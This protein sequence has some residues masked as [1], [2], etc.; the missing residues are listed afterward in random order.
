MFDKTIAVAALATVTTLAGPALADAHVTVQPPQA[1]AGSHAVLDVR[2]PNEEADQRTLSVAVRFP[3]GI[4]S[5]SYEPVPGWRVRVAT[6]KPATPVQ[7]GGRLL[8]EEVDTVTWTAERSADGIRPGQFRDFPVSILVPEGKAGSTLT[9]KAVQTYSGGEV[10]RWIG[11]PDADEPAPR[12][13]LEPAVPEHGAVDHD[14]SEADGKASASA[15]RP[16]AAVADDADDTL[17][18]VLGTV[19]L[20]AGLAGLGVALAGRRRRA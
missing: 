16:A 2:V 12:V 7:S 6:R 15:A 3:P 4:A 18:I 19:G 10:V 13:T 1:A 14:V 11:G 9:F 17:P 8:T 5:A 20:V